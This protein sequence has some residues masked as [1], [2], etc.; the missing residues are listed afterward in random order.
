M[1]LVAVV[2]NMPEEHNLTLPGLATPW[3]PLKAEN[4]EAVCVDEATLPG[5]MLR[6][7]KRLH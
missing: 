6:S 2:F 3:L 1:R 5:V 4:F 7:L